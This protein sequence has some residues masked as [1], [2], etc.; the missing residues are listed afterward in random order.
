[1]LRHCIIVQF[2]ATQQDYYVDSP[3]RNERMII[4]LDLL[5][6]QR[7]DQYDKE[8]VDGASKKI[9]QRNGDTEEYAT[10]RYDTRRHYRRQHKHKTR[11]CKMWTTEIGDST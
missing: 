4:V 5:F 8:R 3:M 7:D 9:R 6:Y 2:S 11:Q 10:I 1:M